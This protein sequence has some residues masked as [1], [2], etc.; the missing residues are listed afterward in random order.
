MPQQNQTSRTETSTQIRNFYSDQLSYMNIKFYNTSLSISLYPFN[1][2]DPNGRSQ[3]D[4]KNGITTTI[5]FEGAFALKY[6]CD[7]IISGNVNDLTLN[8]PCYNASILLNKKPNNPVSLTITKNNQVLAFNF[9]TIQLQV[10]ENGM[11]TTK[12]VESGLGAFMETIN[13]YLNGINADRHLD[14][15]TEDYAKTLG[16]IDNNQN[17]QRNNYSKSNNSY[18]NHNAN[19]QQRQYRNN[20]GNRNYNNQPKQNNWGGPTQNFDN[21]NVPTN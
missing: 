6:A 8:I 10:T 19:N 18:Y 3:Y 15:L 2:N 21:Y 13:G 4:L 12:I 20:N 1:G 7:K 11:Q 17:S 5:S 9:S 16:N 14:K